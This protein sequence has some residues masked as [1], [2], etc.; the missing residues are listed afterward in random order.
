MS[1]SPIQWRIDLTVGDPLG[2]QA[3]VMIGR[4]Y[5]SIKEP[6]VEVVQPNDP[7]NRCAES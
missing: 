5:S 6:Q 3:V 4:W 2:G 7:R 1:H